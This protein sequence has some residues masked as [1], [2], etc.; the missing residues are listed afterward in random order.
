MEPYTAGHRAGS[1]G[2]GQP[3]DGGVVGQGAGAGE[4]G[5]RGVGG[6]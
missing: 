4:A 1:R 5:C 6:R 2:P 3:G